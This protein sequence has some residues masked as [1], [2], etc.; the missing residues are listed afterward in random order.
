[1]PCYD[2]HCETCNKNEIIRISADVVNNDK[3][4]NK[5]KCAQCGNLLI[6]VFS[7]DHAPGIIFKGTPSAGQE[8]RNKRQ[9]QKDIEIANTPFESKQ[10]METGM[11]LAKEEEKKRGLAEGS[12]T[13]GVKMPT[14]K[15]GMDVVKKRWADKKKLS[16]KARGI[17][18]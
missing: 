4:W 16:R 13:T 10:E 2:F 18:T 5:V 12:L 9:A 8:V 15:A 17:K 7:L 6:Q 1:M 14:T 11:G 3:N